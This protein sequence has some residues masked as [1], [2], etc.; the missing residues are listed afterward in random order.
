ML[1]A[2]QRR[3]LHDVVAEPTTPPRVAHRA[4]M[5]LR[6]DANRSDQAASRTAR[7][8]LQRYLE[9]GTDG[10]RDAP[11]SGRPSEVSDST[12][13]R[14]LTQPLYMPTPRWTSRTIAD[15]T[16]IS[17]SAVVRL[18]AH[19]FD[20]AELPDAGAWVSRDRPVRPTGMFLSSRSAAVVLASPPPP[21]PAHP[22][23]LR[24]TPVPGFSMRSPLRA[25][26]QT[27]LAAE[28]VT[29]DTR[30]TRI[31]SDFLRSA[32]PDP[33]VR[34]TLLH[35]SAPDAEIRAWVDAEERIDLVTVAPDRWQALL[36]HLG[37]AM[38]PQALPALEHLAHLVREWAQHPAHA[39]RWPRRSGTPKQ[40]MT[41]SQRVQ[42][43]PSDPSPSQR[44]AESVAAAIQEGV[45]SGRL[46]GGQRVTEAFLIRSTHASRGQVRDALRALASDGLVDLQA[47]KGA[48]VPTP[49]VK[50]VLETYSIRQVL[51]S[52]ILGSVASGRPEALDSV[53]TAL[54][55]LGTIA[56]SGD[57]R[58][59]GEADLDFQ[60]VLASA[61]D[62]RRVPTMFR[63]MT[64]QLRLF[65]SVMGLA[66][67][68]SSDDIVA[69]DTAIFDAVGRRDAATAQQLWQEKMAAAVDYMVRQLEASTPPRS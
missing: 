46:C 32:M 43:S 21:H 15:A 61:A 13:R 64:M 50:D 48:I 69:A 25:P 16:G 3:S 55:R 37:S 44:L 31:T 28:L 65:I 57:T 27:I 19:I 67:A 5:V 49:T 30:A 66:Y 12:V 62:L 63:R 1:T 60:D 20:W 23:D 40:R 34:Y 42:R 36:P 22:S 6:A 35:R 4:H 47:G 38:D 24:R 9:H 10:L 14:V 18:W 39:F 17:Q 59:T 8:W 29:T 41:R 68:Y 54:E 56:R 51:G 2:D 26:L 7:T 33:A 52:L 45:V 11:R 53:E 58:A